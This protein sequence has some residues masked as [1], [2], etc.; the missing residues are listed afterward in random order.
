MKILRYSV[1]IVFA[2]YC[3]TVYAGAF[4]DHEEIVYI[5]NRSLLLGFNSE[6]GGLQQ[7][8]DISRNQLLLSDTNTKRS[9]WEINLRASP[10]TIL[11]DMYSASSFRIEEKNEKY[12]KMVWSNFPEIDNSSFEV[13]VSVRLNEE[14]PVSKWKIFLKG[15]KGIQIEKVVFPKIYGWK[16]M[17]TE[18]L[19]VADWMGALLENPRTYMQKN[20]RNYFSWAYPGNLSMQLLALYNPQKNGLY[21]SCNDSLSYRKNFGVGLDLYQNLFFQIDNFPEYNPSLDIY[22]PN[23]E[24]I[25]GLFRGDWITAAEYYRNWAIQQKWVKNSRLKN[26]LV[27]QWVE[28]TAL[29]VWNRGKVQGVLPPAEAL[30]KRLG[31]PV[32]VLWHWWHGCPY[33]EGFPEYFPPRDGDNLFK[34]QI[35]KAEKQGVKALVY[36]N[37]I[38]WGNAT[39]SWK[40]EN[41]YQYAVKGIEGR[42]ITHVYNIFSG[43]ALTTMCMATPFWREKYATLATKAINEYHVGGIYM[44]QACLSYLCYDSSHGHPLGGGN[45]WIKGSESL[46]NQIRSS[47]FSSRK[48]ALSGEGV[49]ESWLPYVDLFLT[50]QVSK[51]RYAG[52]EG[53]QTIPLFQAVYHPYA[54]SYGSYSSLLSPPYDDLWPK[55]FVPSDTLQL[56]NKKFNEQFLMEQA[57]SF[58]WGI[59]PMIANYRDFLATDRKEEIDYLMK[60]AK[61]RSQGLKYLLHGEFVRAPEMLFPKQQ[62]KISKLSIYVGRDKERITELQ[63]NFSSIYSAAWKSDDEML[64]ISIASILSHSFPLKLKF[65]AGTYGLQSEGEIFLI[66]E[67]SKTKIGKYDKGKIEISLQLSPKDACII[68]FRSEKK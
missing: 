18:N 49:G 9:L 62:L 24:V 37:Q 68:E 1:A 60:L 43:K 67:A 47:S 42:T 39:Q 32:N 20:G 16:D 5:K 38:Q 19:A 56:L 66:R 33:D 41:A 59:Q 10:K 58:A 31:L 65:D 57:R 40:K 3:I 34:N 50:L 8:N 30:K 4:E 52:V 15:I 26:G 46:T 44:D 12:L 23:Y 53:W 27:P 22:I 2:F 29:W 51:E 28:K 11:L 13:I 63:G 21:I 48:I 61:V 17:E 64:G 14:D 45:S 54:I 55:E 35:K 6:N 25:V 7:F 36:M